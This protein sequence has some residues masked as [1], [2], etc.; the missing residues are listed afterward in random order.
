[1]AKYRQFY[2]KF[3]KDQDVQLMPP[4][5]KLILIYLFTNESL[6]DSG[7]YPVTITTIS[8]ETG[9]DAKIVEKTLGNGC[10]KNVAYDKDNCYVFIRKFR[11]YNLGG[12]PQ[13]VEKGICNEFHISHHT[14]LWDEFIKEYPQYQKVLTLNGKPKVIHN[15]KDTEPK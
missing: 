12:N 6:T 13:W 11:K 7:I 3:W 5:D 9:I 4:E 10:L 1:M 15:S 2:P 8:R 14:W